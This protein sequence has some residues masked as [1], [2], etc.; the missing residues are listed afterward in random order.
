MVLGLKD[1]L[2]AVSVTVTS[3]PGAG[4]GVGVGDVAGGVVGDGDGCGVGVGRGE[5]DGDAGDTGVVTVGEGD[6]ENVGDGEPGGRVVGVGA[7]GVRHAASKRIPAIRNR[8]VDLAMACVRMPLLPPSILQ[9]FVSYHQ[10]YVSGG[11][12]DRGG[13]RLAGDA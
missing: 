8:A 13:R 1:R 3:P 9:S 4:D 6:G 5:G 7:D 12:P 11:N 10:F 2:V